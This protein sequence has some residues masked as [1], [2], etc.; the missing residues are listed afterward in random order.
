MTVKPNFPVPFDRRG[1]I[2]RF[3]LAIR[4]AGGTAAV[5]EKSGVPKGTIN[6]L[7]QEG[8]DIRVS[9]AH[10]IAGACDVLLD[11]I[12]TGKAEFWPD[13]YR[14]M[15]GTSIFTPSKEGSQPT[16]KPEFSYL[17]RPEEASEAEDT[18]MRETPPELPPSPLSV[19][20]A[21]LKQAVHLI[22]SLDGLQAVLSDSG[23]E[24]I[25]RAYDILVGA[26]P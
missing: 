22:A 3:R 5:A 23:C 11:W 16:I 13:W 6:N 21:K 20:S 1:M 14:E 2:N 24:R 18:A 15:M 9:N 26:K 4:H 7:L 10:A 19:D 8:A 17:V 25:A 12:T